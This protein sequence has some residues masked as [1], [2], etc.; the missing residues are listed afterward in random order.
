MTNENWPVRNGICHWSL[1]NSHL[2]FSFW[3]ENSP[4]R[5]GGE[6]A[7]SIKSREATEAAQTGWSDRPKHFAELTTPA[8][9][10]TPPLRG[11]ECVRSPF[12]SLWFLPNRRRDVP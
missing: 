2:S 6:A 8:L 7:A 10:A 12:H 9:R 4:P 1:V 3:R 5:R 11:G